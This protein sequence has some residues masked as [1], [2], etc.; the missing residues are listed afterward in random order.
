MGELR[1]KFDPNAALGGQIIESSRVFHQPNPRK[2][3]TGNA[4]KIW[5]NWD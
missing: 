3:M 2:R 4:R 5:Q 1:R